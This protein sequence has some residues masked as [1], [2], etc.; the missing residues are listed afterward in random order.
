MPGRFPEWLRL[1]FVPYTPEELALI[2]LGKVRDMR[3]ALADGPL[4]DSAVVS[5]FARV[6]FGAAPPIT[7]AR[8][9]K[10]RVE[11]AIVMVGGRAVGG[12]SAAP[13]RVLSLEQ[14]SVVWGGDASARLPAVAPAAMAAAVGRLSSATSS[15]A[16]QTGGSAESRPSVEG[17][18]ATTG[19]AVPAPARALGPEQGGVA[20]A[21]ATAEASAVQRGLEAEEA[22]SLVTAAVA[23]SESLRE[24]VEARAAALQQALDAQ[25]AALQQEQHAHATTKAQLQHAHAAVLATFRA[26]AS[27]GL[28]AFVVACAV[29]A[30]VAVPFILTTALSFTTMAIIL[31]VAAAAI[32]CAV[33]AWGW[34]A[35]VAALWWV[36]S[37]LWRLLCAGPGRPYAYLAL[38]TALLYVCCKAAG[39]V[40]RF[41]AAA[42]L[43]IAAVVAWG[44]GRELAAAYR[45][46]VRDALLGWLRAEFGAAV[47][48]EPVAA[49]AAGHED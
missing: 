32:A 30:V 35:V 24:A 36:A 49:A 26:L 47:G 44:T 29:A 20:A 5:A 14:L 8:D 9:V 2:G 37:K 11:H 6:I 23:A 28:A 10:S 33:Y 7:S 34:G 41:H 4:D 19:H 25:A 15:A 38:A 27:V 42:D 46:F 22:A 48:G 43:G 21:V 13:V 16:D 18:A 12:P 1:Q 39:A 31:L 17:S 45:L 40:F 3:W